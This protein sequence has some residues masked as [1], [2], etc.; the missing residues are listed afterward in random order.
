MKTA[1]ARDPANPHPKVGFSSS[2]SA[3]TLYEKQGFK[4]VDWFELEVDDVDEQGQPYRH[5]ARWPY[6]SNYWQ[7]QEEAVEA[8]AKR[9]AFDG[10]KDQDPGGL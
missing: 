5:L 9:I 10:R 1:Q 4:V 2:P 3:R 8:A 7:G 6:M